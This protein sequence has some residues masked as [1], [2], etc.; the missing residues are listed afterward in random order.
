MQVLC[1]MMAKNFHGK[2][3]LKSNMYR[4]QFVKSMAPD[5]ILSMEFVVEGWHKLVS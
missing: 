1:S 2:K 3:M 5:C 4:C